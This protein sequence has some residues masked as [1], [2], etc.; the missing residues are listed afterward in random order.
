MG[1]LEQLKASLWL[2]MT[3]GAGKATHCQP[4]RL[5]TAKEVAERLNV[6]TGF[7]Y[8]N[9]RSY[10]FMVRQGRYLRFSNHGLEQYIKKR[11]GQ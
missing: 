2:K 9:A 5:L 7:V 10:P 4:D 6:T 1:Q 11:Q 8:R 3:T